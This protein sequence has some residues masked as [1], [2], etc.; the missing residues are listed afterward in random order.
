MQKLLLILLLLFIGYNCTA[1]D[2]TPPRSRVTV[3][4]DID[5]KYSGKYYITTN[6]GTGYFNIANSNEP[7]T[8]SFD[9]ELDESY[10]IDIN[11]YKKKFLGNKYKPINIEVIKYN[12]DMPYLVLSLNKNQSNENT[13]NV[14][15]A[16]STAIKDYKAIEK[17]Y[18]IKYVGCTLWL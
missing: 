6:T 4:I 18:I 10:T 5:K 1:Q 13:F 8:K 2:I 3:I 7:D 16:T 15:W 11:I 14:L 17:F 9:F 12:K